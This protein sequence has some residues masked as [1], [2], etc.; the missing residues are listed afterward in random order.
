LEW[1]LTLV[2]MVGG[3]IVAM[4]TG[5]P[6]AFAFMLINVIGIFIFLGGMVGLHQ[7]T[8]SIFESVSSF[9]FLPVPLFILMGEIMFHSGIAFNMIDTLDKWIGRL[10]GRLG[11]LAVVAGTLLA[12]LTGSGT[13]STA[14]LGELL[15]PEME[16]R[17]YKKPMSLGPVLG[18]GGL[19]V[20]IPPSMF[21]VVAAALIDVSVA[22]LLIAGIVP[23]LMMAFLYISYTM[24]RCWLQP[25]IAPSYT[26][27]SIS[28]SQKLVAT[29][30]YVLPLGLVVFS[31]IGV[32]LLGIATPSEAAATGVLSCI[33]LAF[34]N[35]KLSWE[36][37]KKSLSGTFSVTVMIFMIITGSV[38]FSQ[39]LA[40]SG[41]SKGM[42]EFVMGLPLSPIMLIIASQVILL[43]LGTFMGSIS[44]LMIT[45]PIFMPIV[46]ALGFNP[47]LFG[48]LMLLNME[49]SATTPP[50]GMSLFV[51]K[52]IAPKDTTMGE[53]YRAG[54]P[55]LGCDA[56]VMAI[57]L[58]FP[59]VVLWLSRLMK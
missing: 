2:I 3:L 28:L 55:Y 24:M 54:L 22:E 9:V 29:A 11:V 26:I 51:M 18:S 40:F 27:E 48:L 14:V 43:I 19:A 20:M 16:R 5:M 46:H 25:S 39:I 12:A 58:I 59:G 15:V 17:G 35:R 6:V 30:K 37:L 7:L 1:Q 57:M 4:A 33:I 45:V 8:L 31:V 41:A 56:V 49:M 21:A 36:V 23:G 42:T 53:I 47:L 10:P 34:F 32:I 52:G 50:F 38:V 44:M 13:A